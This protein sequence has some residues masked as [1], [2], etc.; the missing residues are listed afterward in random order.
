MKRIATKKVANKAPGKLGKGP[1][2]VKEHNLAK[3]KKARVTTQPINQKGN[4]GV[5]NG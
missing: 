4:Y 3:T 2:P 1:K 5:K